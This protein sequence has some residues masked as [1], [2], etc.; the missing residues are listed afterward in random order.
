MEYYP[1]A[2]SSSLLM[3]ASEWAKRFKVNKKFE[4]RQVKCL[5]ENIYG[6][7]VLLCRYLTE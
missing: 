4:D 6:Q 5:G 7:S 3:A 1:G 2:E